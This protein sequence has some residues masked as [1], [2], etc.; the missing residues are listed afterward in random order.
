M[1]AIRR[2][3]CLVLP[4]ALLLGGCRQEPDAALEVGRVGF[5]EEAVVD[6]SPELREALVDLAALGEA[7]ARGELDV[8][9][10]PLVEREAERARLSALAVALGAEE[11]GIGEVELRQAYEADPEWELTVRHAVRLVPRGA[12]AAER[13]EARRIA[14]EV[15]RRAQT[16]EPFPTLAAEFS[17]EPGAAERGG[18]LRP[19]REGTWVEPFWEAASRLDP[20]EVSPVVETEYGYH[21]LRLEDRQP[22]PF[23]EADRHRLLAGLVPPARAAAA[24]ERWAAEREEVFSVYPPAI[25]AAREMV[26][27][28]AAPDT[29]VLAR[30]P[31]GEYTAWDLALLRASLAPEERE[32]LARAGDRAYGEEVM[33]DAR[34]EMW[35]DAARGMGVEPPAGARERAR[36]EWEGRAARWAAAFGFREGM[37]PEAVR[38]AALQ[39]LSAGG[40]EARIARRELEAARPLLRRAYP[41]R[42]PSAAESSSE[43]RNS[44]STR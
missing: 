10:E 30:W 28:G 43:T 44:E 42:G 31:E 24:M 32:R 39:G 14:E 4:T 27:T 37:R 18:L 12:S 29:L 21:V 25:L 16:G 11:M 13:E 38:A 36:A 3:L 23:E 17:E 2:T 22:V 41:P 8:L 40:Q 35:T 20:G 34:R 33:G 19:G 5:P 15:R 26:R 1:T 6:L 7:T 9:G